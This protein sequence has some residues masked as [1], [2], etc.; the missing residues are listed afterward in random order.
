ML[1]ADAPLSDW[2][3]W[4]ESLSP[5]EID[6]G[7]ARVEAVLERLQLRL[8]EHVLTIAGTNGK[9]SSAAMAGALLHAAGYKVGTYTSP[10]IVD[11]NERI[12][13]SESSSGRRLAGDHARSRGRR[14][15]GDQVSC[16]RRLAGD[17]EIIE[18]FTTI[19]SVRN[20]VPLTYFEY[21]TLAAFVVFANA[22]LD[23]WILEVGMGGRLDATNVIDPTGVLITN[24]ALDHC[25]WLGHDVETIAREKAGVMRSGVP[26]VFGSTN[27]PSTI[28]SH[29]EEIGAQLLLAGRDFTGDGVPQPGLA[30]SFQVD[31]AAAVLA[32]LEAAGLGR[33][34]EKDLVQEVLPSIGLTG[35]GQRIE[36]GG[37]QW[38][39][40]V[41]HNP[42][43]A[44][45]LAA[46][47]QADPDGGATIAIVAMLDDKDV[48]G[49]VANLDPHVDLWIATAAES[50]RAI[51][52]DELARR[53]ANSSDRPCLVTDNLDAALQSARRAA[54]R[55]D[56][57]LV[58]GSFYVVGP[59]LQFLES[60]PQS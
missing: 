29:A 17:A 49:I 10:H 46:T 36:A 13:I 39:L 47:L 19:E 16:G 31:N 48:E 20:D 18:A 14:L 42:A 3:T 30:G 45:V 28:V 21:G 9:G 43:A 33:A 55:N 23:V 38:L 5:N 25:E 51:R 2:L 1:S 24:I 4:L 53:I 54:A 32:L 7:L 26:A 52:S 41:A 59:V 11:Y 56:K 58:T 40:D 27:I 35:R 44:E 50:H 37:R 34:T 22:G 15:A 8:P 60:L 6:L 12:A 57:I